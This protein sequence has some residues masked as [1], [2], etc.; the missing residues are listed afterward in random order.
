MLHIYASAF[1]RKTDKAL[2]RGS[3]TGSKSCNSLKACALDEAHT[4]LCPDNHDNTGT[5][6]V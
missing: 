6:E 5:C 2:I 4:R 3:G 1:E